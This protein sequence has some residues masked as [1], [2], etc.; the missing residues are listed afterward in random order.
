MERGLM[1]ESS[2]TWMRRCGDLHGHS[3]YGAGDHQSGADERP[4]PC[5]VEFLDNILNP[6]KTF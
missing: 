6:G 2:D 4:I 5:A 1:Y 3:L